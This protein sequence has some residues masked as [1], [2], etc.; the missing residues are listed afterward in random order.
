MAIDKFRRNTHISSNYTV[1]AT[2]KPLRLVIPA[3]HR[4]VL[5]FS[6]RQLS[7]NRLSMKVLEAVAISSILAVK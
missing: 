1:C 3:R 7:A 4:T 2:T 5:K 6:K